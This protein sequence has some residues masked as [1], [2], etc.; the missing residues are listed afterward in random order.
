MRGNGRSPMKQMRSNRAWRSCAQPGLFGVLRTIGLLQFTQR[1]HDARES[2]P[3]RGGAGS[4]SGPWRN[5][6]ALSSFDLSFLA[7]PV[8]RI[9]PGGDVLPQPAPARGPEQALELASGVAQASGLG[10]RRRIFRETAPKHALLVFPEKFHRLEVVPI[11]S[12]TEA[13]STRSC[14]V[15]AVFGR[16]RPLPVFM[17]ADQSNPRRFKSSAATDESTP[18]DM[19]TT[20]RSPAIDGL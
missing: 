10:V 18:P 5:S 13:Q 7:F 17:T 12:A 2:A 1:K 9:V 20:M 15:G 11:I 6:T 8:P 14:R 16:R 4:S 19:P 3:E